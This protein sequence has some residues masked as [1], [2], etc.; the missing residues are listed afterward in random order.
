MRPRTPPPGATRHS[1]HSPSGMYSVVTRPPTRSPLLL[2]L[3]EAVLKFRPYS[4][5][6]CFGSSISPSLPENQGNNIH[7]RF[8]DNAFKF[9]CVYLVKKLLQFIH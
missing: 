4:H 8:V 1:A 2:T 7:K 9:I 3:D 6:Q 5:Q